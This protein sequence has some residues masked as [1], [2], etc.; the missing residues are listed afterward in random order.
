MKHGETKSSF[1]S[2]LQDS[3]MVRNVVAYAPELFHW[4]ADQF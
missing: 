4:L 3:G 2:M 1:D